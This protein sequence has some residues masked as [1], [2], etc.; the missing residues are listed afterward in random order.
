L[1]FWNF[2]YFYVPLPA[3]S[4][5][6]TI[7][8]MSK[9]KQ[10]IRILLA[11]V[12]LALMALVTDITGFRESI[13]PEIAALT[14]GF[15]VQDKQIWRINR[16]KTLLLLS[17]VAITAVLIVNY[18]PGPLT[19]RLCLV[20]I[21]VAS[22]LMAM[23]VTLTP[24]FAVGMLPVL[25]GIDSYLYPLAV[26]IIVSI[27]VLGQRMMDAS[28]LREQEELH[29][30]MRPTWHTPL[31]WGALLLTSLPLMIAA[32]ETG[33][34]FCLAPPL[35]VTF[36][37]LSNSKGGFRFR[38]LQTWGMLVI[39]SVI[40]TVSRLVI[41]ASLG[42]GKSLAVFVAESLVFLMFSLFGKRF[43]P[44]AAITL[45]PFV[46]PESSVV[47]FPVFAIIG[48]TYFILIAHTL[49]IKNNTK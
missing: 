7:N 31:R 48:A 6:D 38:L 13:I 39:A 22:L 23:N 21:I 18:V 40:G 36:I 12:L 1:S 44:A 29:H 19:G 42:L 17:I 5:E 28:G 14:V 47:F 16:W 25:L 43:A 11:L 33:Y 27:I 20:F 30:P 46:I 45:I 32:E 15:W 34:R 24:A 41:C 3:I 8:K 2:Q 4:K 9:T 26:F 10:N 35:I 49:F 37:E